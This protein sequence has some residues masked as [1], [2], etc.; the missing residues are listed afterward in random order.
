MQ[1]TMP[2]LLG[3]TIL[4][5]DGGPKTEQGANLPR[6]C[7]LLHDRRQPR[8]QC[9]AALLLV[10]SPAAEAE[11]AVRAALRQAEDS[12]AFLA[13]ATAIRLRRDARF[14]EE[15][16]A[17]LSGGR[18]QVRQAAADTLAALPSPE[19]IDR[20]A[21]LADDRRAE[22]GV[23]QA[24][25]WALGRSGR[26]QAA[27]ILL[28]HLEGSN[29]ALRR[30]AA[31]ALAELSGEDHGLDAAGWR[32]WWERHRHAG[33]ENWLEQRLDYQAGRAHRLEGELARVRA[34][35]LRLEQQLYGRLSAAERATHVQALA[36]EEDAALRLLAVNCS[37]DL[38]ATA[39]RD[40]R[41]ALTGVLLRLSHDGALEVQRAAVLGLGRVDG[42]AAFDRLQVLLESGEPAVRRVAARSLA[43]QV[44]GSDEAA[45]GR[46]RQ[47]VPVLSKALGDPSLEVVVEAAE[48]LGM[49]GARAA[50]PVLTAL[51]RHPA[52]HVRQTAAQALERSAEPA[53]LDDLLAGLH[54]A[55]AAVRFSLVGALVHAAGDGQTLTS[56][57]QQRLLAGLEG[58]LRDD[59][60]GV[61]SR[62]A[63]AL[64]ECGPPAVLSPLWA[65]V[66]SAP[67]SRVRDKAWSAMIDLLARSGSAS[68]LQEWDHRL[69]DDGHGQRRLQ[70]LTEVSA[71]WQNRPG[72]EAAA[73]A[74]RAALER[75][76]QE[77][78]KSSERHTPPDD[79]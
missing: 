66:C 18:P 72:V 28:T 75:A 44:R 41:E 50:G 53:A 14:V 59:D 64:G 3:L 40:R 49:L 33:D 37:L 39:D 36:D 35:V 32:L 34:R 76:Q 8:G 62:A 47:A 23:R 68:L 13:L 45:Q 67:D 63:T 65:C 55:S 11:Q 31:E 2:I 69:A 78:G 30:A 74:A 54:D 25:L 77:T 58:R 24:A 56:A 38:L 6:L 27:A 29:E 16:F 73:Q 60:P 15:L 9:Q 7:E 71:R 52:E 61:R 43:L 12:D 57:Q 46:Q 1:A 17:A 51:L 42:E 4:L 26:K 70:L 19:V 5:G 22:P 20:L 10:E 48:G 21:K 79:E